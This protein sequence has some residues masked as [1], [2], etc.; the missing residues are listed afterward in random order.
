MRLVEGP[1]F[2]DLIKS[3]PHYSAGRPI[4]R[5]TAVDIALRAGWHIGRPSYHGERDEWT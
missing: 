1:D 3:L 2:L 5:V 4:S